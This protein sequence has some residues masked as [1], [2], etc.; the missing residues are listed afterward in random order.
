MIRTLR[1]LWNRTGGSFSGHRRESDLTEELDAHIQLL[2]EDNIRRGV[3][4]DD[5][6]RHA[7]L[8]F[9]SVESAKES[10]R[11]QRG[12]PALDAI[13]QDLRYAFRWIR[14]NPGFAAIAILSLGIGIG[15][16]TAIFSLVNTVL[17][18]PLA[19]QDPD[20]VFTIREVVFDS[21]GQR[22]VTPVNPVHAREWAKHCP[23]LEQVALMGASTANVIAGGEPASI[24]AVDVPHNFFALFGVE[25]ILGRPFLPEEEKEGSNPVVIL[26]E[27]LWRSRFSADRSLIGRSILVDG[28]NHE[29]VGIV[30]GPLRLPYHGQT[31][32]RFEI[33]RPLVLAQEELS[34]IMGN[35]NYGAVLRVK[36]GVSAEQALAEINVVQ[37][38][39]PAQLGRKEDLKAT[40]IP[41]H[42]LFVGRARLGLW[43]LAAAVGAVLLI[44]CI[45]LANL[46][47][48]RI[49]SR[50]REAAIR[51]ALGASRGRQFRMVLTESLMLAVCGGALGLLLASWSVQALVATT[52]LDIPRLEEL[53]VDSNVLMFAFCITLL[54]GL[55]FGALPAWRLTRNDPQQA[56]RAGSH[57]VTEG[58]HGLRVREGLISVEVAL[59]AALLI[60]AA[61]LTSSLTRLLQVDKGFDADRVLTVDI[62]LTGSLY[63]EAAHRENFFNRILPKI[64][65]IP[66]VQASGVVTYLPTLGQIWNDPIYLE[67][68]PR[69]SRYPVDNRYASPGYFRTMNIAIRA[70]R[71]FEENDRGR[72]VAML[73]ARAAKLLWPTDPNPVGR[74]F[75]GEDDKLKTLVGIVAEV[76]AELHNEAPPTAYY[77]Y[78]QRA[79]DVVSLVVRTT[80]DP[81]TAVGAIRATLR[82]EDAQLP[83]DTIR[84]MEEV[85]DR[86]VAQRRFQI[87][88]MAVFAASAL[89][90]ASLGIY[91]VV[92]YSVARR[93]NEIGIR[94]ALGAQRSQ[95]LGL[96]VRQGMAP[97]LVGLA[98]GVAAGLMLSRAIRSLLFEVQ[99][100]DP[101]TVAG[102][103]GVLLAVG[104][105]A[106]LIPAR[107]AAGTDAIAALRFE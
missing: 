106:C 61:L 76:R 19:Y 60:V 92:S 25:P 13:G 51:T 40:L 70:G 59:S 104:V 2:A 77:P 83:I 98:A 105:S 93:R 20:R 21:R 75:M 103:T 95:L 102:V 42:E 69:E 36:R 30:P 94:M 44:V 24:P 100:A 31:N 53:R 81:Q 50:S 79:P 14:K 55:V 68:A 86:S 96:I 34:R 1:R 15:A 73:S 52:N 4:P 87:T 26:S 88:L 8:Q 17:L 35:F 91:G 39:F 84:T 28:Q 37:A 48:S 38:R 47:L 57:T 7:K 54:T 80:G 12:L 67:G 16:N 45:N 56:L 64:G 99:P 65:S 43:V 33:F 5:A 78:W 101:L 89:L 90:V 63:A 71:A 58:R 32:A 6:L 11:D 97:V 66:G 3:P 41:A 85:V 23:S 46:L 49:A 10:Y 72:G 29:V 22:S 74:S 9:G 107:R 18:K 27:S 62:G 82:G